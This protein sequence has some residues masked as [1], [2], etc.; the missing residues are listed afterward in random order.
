MSQA[1]FFINL[2]N[3]SAYAT[4]IFTALN[5]I[6]L[7][8]LAI[9]SFKDRKQLKDWVGGRW[10]EDV[11]FSVILG[12]ISVA[13]LYAPRWITSF[14]RE[15][16][17]IILFCYGVQIFLHIDYKKLLA[18]KLQ[19]GWYRTSNN[20]CKWLGIVSLISVLLFFIGTIAVQDF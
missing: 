6:M 4:E 15:I 11:K 2:Q 17:V 1:S 14:G 8:E 7:I 12:I 20:I 19:K 3:I 13:L 10:R 16:Y 9:N 5:A 18:T